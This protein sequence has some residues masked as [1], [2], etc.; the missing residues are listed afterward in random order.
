M[1]NVAIR[2]MRAINV[3]KFVSVT[4]IYISQGVEVGELVDVKSQVA[5]PGIGTCIGFKFDVPNLRQIAA[6]YLWY[7]P[8]G[9]HIVDDVDSK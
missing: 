9:G 6:Q 3:D 7:C 5:G 2:N 8:R 4:R 1:I